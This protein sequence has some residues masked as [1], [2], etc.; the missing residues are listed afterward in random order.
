LLCFLLLTFFSTIL[1]FKHL[2]RKFGIP[3]I[4]DGGTR[5]PADFTKA[6]G[7]G[8]NSVLAGSI[9]AA[10]PESAAE[11]VEIDGKS[12]KLYAGMASEYVQN[13]WKNGLKAGTCAEGG[14][15]YLDIGP[16][17]DKLLELYSGALRSGITY[18]GAKDVKSFQDNVEF[19][20]IK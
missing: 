1:K 12:K 3:V 18:A 4:S 14:I 15:R 10:C 19:V 16:T 2:S 9:F 5:E 7:A 20:L 6:I 11:I 13:K 8:A 17:A